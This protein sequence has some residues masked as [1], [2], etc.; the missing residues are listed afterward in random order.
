MSVCNHLKSSKR[1][2]SEISKIIEES[3]TVKSFLNEN[4][5]YLIKKYLNARNLCISLKENNG[6]SLYGSDDDLKDFL[7][8]YSKE[9]LFI[10]S[11]INRK[12]KT[13][14]LISDD[15]LMESFPLKFNKETIGHLYIAFQKNNAQRTRRKFVVINELIS[16]ALDKFLSADSKER[17][18]DILIN[19][20][21]KINSELRSLDSFTEAAKR[22]FLFLE[23]IFQRKILIC[24]RE[25][26]R[27]YLK[28]NFKISNSKVNFYLLSDEKETN[29]Y[30]KLEGLNKEDFKLTVIIFKNNDRDNIRRDDFFLK[31]L[32][33]EIE[34]SLERILLIEKVCKAKREW[35]EIF[36]SIKD[37]ICVINR[38]GKI[39]RAN[40]AAANLFKK[41]FKEFIGTSYKKLFYPEF[42]PKI[43]KAVESNQALND[44]IYVRSQSKVFNLNIFPIKKQNSSLM[45][46]GVIIS[47]IT[48]K[49]I[50]QE[51]LLQASKL[52]SVGQLSA[53]FAH[54]IN[55][56]LTLI[57]GLADLW[58][59]KN[60]SYL[61]KEENIKSLQEDLV[62]IEKAALQASDIIKKLLQ[63][64]K[65]REAEDKAEINV[66]DVIKESVDMVKKIYEV[67]GIRINLDLGRNLPL[68]RVNR[69]ALH[70]AIINIMENAKDAILEY[71]KGS[72]IEIRTNKKDDKISLEIE[73]DGPGIDPKIK[74]MIF[75]P[76]FTTKA[77]G[78]GTGL[79]LT[80]CLKMIH[81]NEG[82]ITVGEGKS[83][84]AL[85]RILFPTV[86]SG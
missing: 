36:D 82:I 53:G 79:G 35:E 34:A 50:L 26:N 67:S 9:D 54:E 20:I 46:Y 11:V 73:D 77:P 24:V 3:V 19:Y 83:G 2:I 76:F 62:R 85:F 84:G 48:E 1:I 15:Y 68:I 59:E 30:I 6:I 41:S 56:P 45:T 66:N 42:N 13:S 10:K 7:S 64:T 38:E 40:K 43:G 70:Q 23:R 51:Q 8:I 14:K 21:N 33:N 80:I 55:N 72:K 86:F 12:D 4:T 57:I 37:S 39:V 49:K 22:I 28:A 78:K 69:A 65:Y 25:D 32:I 18:I 44:E 52:I 58:L 31:I 27:K 63:Y 16:K 17:E 81:E 74:S 75:E 71:Q 47:D 61:M 60:L 5:L 29:K